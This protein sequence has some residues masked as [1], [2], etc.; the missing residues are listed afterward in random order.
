MI[1]YYFSSQEEIVLSQKDILI[2]LN[3]MFAFLAHL[4]VHVSGLEFYVF[5][6]HCSAQVILTIGAFT[7]SSFQP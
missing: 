4:H 5:G 7:S 6:N 1:I 2:H 3:E